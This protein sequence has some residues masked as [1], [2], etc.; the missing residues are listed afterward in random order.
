M[1]SDDFMEIENPE[2]NK[3]TQLQ[4]SNDIYNNSSLQN[5]E[6]N[7]VSEKSFIILEDMQPL[8]YFNVKPSHNQDED[9]ST[10]ENSV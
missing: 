4:Q 1:P 5:L 2:S 8:Y 7:K 6:G 9:D 3:K 10:D